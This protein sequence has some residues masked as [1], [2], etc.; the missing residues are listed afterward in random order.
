M[1][2][3][4]TV[5]TQNRLSVT[6]GS[7]CDYHMSMRQVQLYDKRQWYLQ[8]LSCK[9]IIRTGLDST[10]ITLSAFPVP[11]EWNLR[12]WVV[13]CVHFFSPLNF[14]IYSVGNL[15]FYAGKRQEEQ[16]ES[17]SSFCFRFLIFHFSSSPKIFPPQHLMLSDIFHV[18]YPVWFIIWFSSEQQSSSTGEL[19]LCTFNCD[20]KALIKYKLITNKA[21]CIEA[22]M[23]SFS[24]D[25]F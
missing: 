24:F 16:T 19:R 25:I 17:Q 7:Q 1:I 18:R 22:A 23:K 11:R 8:L 5:A 10:G 20:E 9:S 13:C 2:S 6:T 3:T 12:L 14:I 21:H 15:K 4:T